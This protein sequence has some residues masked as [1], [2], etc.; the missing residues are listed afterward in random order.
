[1]STTHWPFWLPCRQFLLQL[2]FAMTK[3]KAQGQTMSIV[4]FHLWYNMSLLMGNCMWDYH[5]QAI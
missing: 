4:S 5:V 2:A 3:N 1:M